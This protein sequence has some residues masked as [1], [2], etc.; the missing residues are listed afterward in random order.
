MLESNFIAFLKSKYPDTPVYSFY[1]PEDAPSPAFCFE[2]AGMGVATHYQ[3]G[4]EIKTRSIKLTLSSTEVKDI[5]DDGQLHKYIKEMHLLGSLNILNARIIN[6]TDDFHLEQKIFERT[7][8][9]SIKY[10]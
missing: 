9:I 6:F 2:N 8:T 4:N 10:R 1:I 5:F 7:Y 3:D